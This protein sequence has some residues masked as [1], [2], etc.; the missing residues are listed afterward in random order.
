MTDTMISTQAAKPA[1]AILGKRNLELA[2]FTLD[3][4]QQESGP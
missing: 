1:L 3:E 4:A 2:P